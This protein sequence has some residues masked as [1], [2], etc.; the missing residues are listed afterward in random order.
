MV[1]SH[2]TNPANNSVDQLRTIAALC[3]DGHFDAATM[4]LPIPERIVHGDAT[5]QAI[6]RFTESLGDVADVRRCWRVKYELAFNS[7]NKYMIK[8]FGMAHPDGPALALPNGIA[9]AFEMGDM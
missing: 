6:L 5:D 8:A 7:K 4:N 1:L 9:A 3:N 2:N